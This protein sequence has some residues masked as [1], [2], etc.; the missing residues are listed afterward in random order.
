MFDQVLPGEFHYLPDSFPVSGGVAV[1]FAF[2]TPGLGVIGAE[3][4]LGEAVVE[5]FLTLPAEDY[6]HVF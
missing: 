4:E 3:K 2:L 1:S 5:E 6:F